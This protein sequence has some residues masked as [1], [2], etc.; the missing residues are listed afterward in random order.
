M[1]EKSSVSFLDEQHRV[2]SIR[3]Y[4]A[5]ASSAIHL[6]TFQRGMKAECL[7][8]HVNKLSLTSRDFV[9]SDTRTPNTERNDSNDRYRA[10]SFVNSAAAA[11]API[12][13]S[14]RDKYR[15]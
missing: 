13:R 5:S 9:K 6:E 4:V 1:L 8:G 15:F 14:K 11:A 10:V 7:S 3:N 2:S 12:I